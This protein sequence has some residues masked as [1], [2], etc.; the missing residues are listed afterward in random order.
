MATPATP[1]RGDDVRAKTMAGFR[2]V[3]SGAG[4]G[5]F[6]HEGGAGLGDE[7]EWEE[8]AFRA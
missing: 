1:S 3:L 8:G 6:Y 4:I 2:A 7:L 5:T